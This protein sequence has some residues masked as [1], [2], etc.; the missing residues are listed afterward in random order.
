MNKMNENDFD[1]DVMPFT[2]ATYVQ[3]AE[4]VEYTTSN[5]IMF[6]AQL[7]GSIEGDIEWD[8]STNQRQTQTKQNCEW[9]FHRP[10]NP[11]PPS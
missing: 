3:Y 1:L 8:Y 11:T 6:S 2:E 5:D 4:Q 9:Y 7:I 10:E